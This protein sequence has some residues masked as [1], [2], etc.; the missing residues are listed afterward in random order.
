MASVCLQDPHAGDYT[1]GKI[2]HGVP[3][4]GGVQPATDL[5][6]RKEQQKIKDYGNLVNSV[7]ERV[8]KYSQIIVGT[9]D[10]LDSRSP[11]DQRNFRINI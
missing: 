4:G 8:S 5:D 6:R 9:H 10:C 11:F 2:Q 1:N 3:R 7:N